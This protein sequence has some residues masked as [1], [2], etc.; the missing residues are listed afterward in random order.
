MGS[1][2]I[3]YFFGVEFLPLL[4]MVEQV[5]HKHL[6][7]SLLW[8]GTQHISL[9]ISKCASRRHGSFYL[10]R[11]YVPVCLMRSEAAFSN[12]CMWVGVFITS[13]CLDWLFGSSP[14]LNCELLDAVV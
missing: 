7:W 9:F 4:V 11:P 13:L 10:R 5:N 8:Y 12:L 3:M 14:G 2:S 6:D 1:D